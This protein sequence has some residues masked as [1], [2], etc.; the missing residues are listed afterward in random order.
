[1]PVFEAASVAPL[2]GRGHRG[3]LARQAGAELPEVRGSRAAK[4]R[5]K[6]GFPLPLGRTAFSSGSAQSAP[7]P[8][9]V[10]QDEPCLGTSHVQ[11]SS[12]AGSHGHMH[13]HRHAHPWWPTCT[14]QDG[15]AGTPLSTKRLP[16]VLRH[17]RAEG[18]SQG[19]RGGTARVAR[20][21]RRLRPGEGAG[22]G[23]AEERAGAG[24]MTGG[25]GRHGARLQPMVHSGTEEC[26]CWL[27]SLRA[28]EMLCQ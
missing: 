11:G 24:A 7:G 8:A 6:P 14:I 25:R 3:A 16:L 19:S 4:S 26:L 13:P 9:P 18:R 22:V 23:A 20:L 12:A 5:A 1:M 17:S 2:G 10:S 21:H 27:M 28:E 15:T